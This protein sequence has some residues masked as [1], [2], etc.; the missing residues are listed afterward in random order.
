MNLN[1]L[2][3]EELVNL[4]ND[5]ENKIHQ[6]KDGFFYICKVRSYGRN[7]KEKGIYNPYTLQ[8][9]CNKYSG[10]DGIVDVFTNNPNLDIDN[11][12]DVMY[13][14]TQEDY[15]KWS[16]Y[17]YFKNNIPSFEK[18][19]LEWNNRENIHFNRRPL[20]EPVHTWKDIEN[21]KNDMLNLEGQFVEPTSLKKYS[22]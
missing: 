21:Y 13:V 19:L 11:Y 3:I 1:N 22:Y 10:D 17:T 4:K 18:E 16:D 2:T 7:W 20:F 14:P 15:I 6:F 9:L 8:E 12:G 5:I